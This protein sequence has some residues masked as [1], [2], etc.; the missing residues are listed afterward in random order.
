MVAVWLVSPESARRRQLSTPPG[1]PTGRR[2]EALEYLIRQFSPEL[3]RRTI[4]GRVDKMLLSVAAA[5]RLLNDV[6][7][8]HLSSF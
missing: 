1:L 4:I 5:R 6:S 2:R 3:S 7:I 8:F